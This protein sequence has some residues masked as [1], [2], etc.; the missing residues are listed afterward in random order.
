MAD[1]SRAGPRE[2]SGKVAIVEYLR[3][4]AALSVAWFHLTNTYPWGAV[5]HSGSY[6]WL[7]V[8]VFFVI[9]GFVL[10]LSIWGHG[11][12]GY[13]FA[14]FAAFAK[15]RIIRIEP[16]YLISVA[17]AV[18]L[19]QISSLLPA[20]RGH[21]PNLAV[22]Q[23]LS[24]IAYLPPAFG[25]PWL[26]PV[27]WTLAYEFCFYGIVGVA[28]P[29]LVRW[30]LPT[31]GAV[32]AMALLAMVAIFHRLDADIPLF[33]MGC[34]VFLQRYGLVRRL[35]AILVICLAGLV[36]F[37]ADRATGLVGTGTALLLV[38]ALELRL[39]ATIHASLIWL[40]S[41]SYSLYITHVPIG[42]RVINLG[43]RFVH[44]EPMRL[45]LS[46]G[47]LIICLLFAAGFSALI[48]RPFIRLSKRIRSRSRRRRLSPAPSGDALTDAAAH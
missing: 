21:G 45:A 4:L 19:W 17:L 14:D 2:V 25:Y 38:F 13:Q 40:A 3:A 27:Y 7:G 8:A 41:I 28:Y 31:V 30:P 44:S 35:G 26:Q 6:G 29:A 16:P 48:E 23:V 36:S 46:V 37:S 1:V 33:T 47:A 9:S 12:S 11:G 42:G 43:A 34:A 20:F 32:T 15:R 22:G 39:G 24:H 18:I 10:P 5:R